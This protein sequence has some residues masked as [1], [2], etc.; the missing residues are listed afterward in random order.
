MRAKELSVELRDITGEGWQINSAP[1]K[2]PKNTVFS[3][4]LNWKKFG[5]TKTHSRLFLELAA[6]QTEQLGEKGLGQGDD[7]ELSC[8]KVNFLP[9]LRY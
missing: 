4:I 9:S 8:W 3:I 2:V 1:L 6:G 5:T 7:Q